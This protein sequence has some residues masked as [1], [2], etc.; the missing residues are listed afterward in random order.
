MEA[1]SV[2]LLVTTS[3]PVAL[4]FVVEIEVKEG[5]GVLRNAGAAAAEF[6]HHVAHRES[7]CLSCSVIRLPCVAAMATSR[8]MEF[9]QAT[10]G[11]CLVS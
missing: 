6:P 4:S 8:L 11:A 3:V 1:R 2:R 7:A 10:A 9:G 5:V